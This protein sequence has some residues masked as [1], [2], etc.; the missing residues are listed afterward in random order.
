VAA[1]HLLSGVAI[2]YGEH[3]VDGDSEVEGGKGNQPQQ[4]E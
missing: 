1:T 3:W 4:Y 2:S